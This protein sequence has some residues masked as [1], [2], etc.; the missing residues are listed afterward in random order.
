MARAKIAGTGFYVPEKVLTNFDLERLVDTSDEWIKTRT[1]IIE[2]RIAG[3]NEAASDLGKKAA[4]EAMKDAGVKPEDIDLI[5]VATTTPD[6]LLPATA[7]FIQESIGAKN[8]AAMDVHA[9][10]A[11]F[12][13]CLSIA[14]QYIQTGTYGNIL[15]VGTEV[16]SRITDWQDRNTCILF[17]DGA[18]AAVIQASENDK[19]GIV[20][21]HIH[22]DGSYQ[23]Y[24]IVPGG[25]SRRPIS[26]E[27]INKR[28]NFIKMKGN[29]TFKVAVKAMT[30]A[31]KC[32]LDENGHNSSDI[33]YLIPHQ[34]N[35]RI[36]Q[37]I[38]KKLG[39]PKEKVYINLDRFGNTSAASIP[40]AL[41]EL[42][43]KK[44]LVKGDLILLVGL[45]AGFAWG[46]ALIRM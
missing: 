42:R 38:A 7:C 45:G 23:D 26:E 46:S 15:V 11:G 36:I 3:E 40:I 16:L 6:S 34:A 28:L 27:V 1:G 4:L 12:V 20:S 2:R 22:S 37:A 8:A 10:C 13:F 30:D 9:A 29:E 14:D 44:A 35:R 31:A 5:L 17:G 33:K 32:V 24:L 21:I 43:R 39:L 41:H 18:G 25:G 19:E